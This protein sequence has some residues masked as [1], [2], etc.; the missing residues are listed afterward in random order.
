MTLKCPSCGSENFER[1]RRPT[2]HVP[3]STFRRHRCLNCR[4][5]FLTE[6][7][8]VDEERAEEITQMLTS[9]PMPESEAITA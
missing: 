4:R 8:V 5:V 3:D 7:R 2:D 9:E 1:Y 6:Q